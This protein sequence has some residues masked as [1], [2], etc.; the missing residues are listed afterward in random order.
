MEIEGNYETEVVRRIHV[1]SSVRLLVD[2]QRLLHVVVGRILQAH[3]REAHLA[4]N[5]ALLRR[6][7]VPHLRLLHQAVA[8]SGVTTL[9]PLLLY[10]KS[11][12]I[13]SCQ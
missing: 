11:G 1:A 4:G 13:F 2:L 12:F 9:Q 8:L 10:Y 6:R 5:V 7:L 3:L